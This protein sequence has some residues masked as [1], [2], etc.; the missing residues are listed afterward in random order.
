MA[1]NVGYEVLVDAS[2]TADKKAEL[3]RKIIQILEPQTLR[4]RTLW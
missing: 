2:V 1:I 4:L 3:A